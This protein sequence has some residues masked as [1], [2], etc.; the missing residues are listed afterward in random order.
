MAVATLEL[1]LPV[2]LSLLSDLVGKKVT[3][4]EAAAVDLAAETS[5]VR[6]TYLGDLQPAALFYMDVG[7]AASLGA[8]LVMMPAGLVKESVQEKNLLPMLIDNSYEV[9]NVISRFINRAGG[10]HY[11]LREQVLP[12]QPLPADFA[13][14]ADG[15]SERVDLAL[16]VDGYIGG[17]LTILVK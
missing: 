2:A 7:L 4:Q 9:L 11:K 14:V 8:A 13:E 5:F 16:N 15:A 17:V 3:G 6:G 10:V 1:S 12:G